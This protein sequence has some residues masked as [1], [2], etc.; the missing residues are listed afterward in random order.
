MRAR[1]VLLA[2]TLLA[3]TAGAAV[4][5]Q[6][7]AT[8]DPRQL[9]AIEGKVAQYSLTPRGDVDGLIV[10]AGLGRVWSLLCKG[11]ATPKRSC[12]Q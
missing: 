8:Y 10:S 7:I 5:A 12:E 6:D 11:A 1:H 2:A 9:P 3:G 4:H